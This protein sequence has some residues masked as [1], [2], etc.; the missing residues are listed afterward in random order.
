L[1][2]LP[3]GA[4]VSSLVPLRRAAVQRGLK[5]L[6]V[7]SQMNNPINNPKAQVT[8]MQANR[9]VP[10]Y[11]I[12]FEFTG[13]STMGMADLSVG[14]KRVCPIAVPRRPCSVRSRT[15]ARP[16]AAEGGG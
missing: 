12:D 8:P 6:S 14:I 2:E 3:R 7:I 4:T 11:F 10:W 16:S 13:T 1:E 5:T 9:S 15:N